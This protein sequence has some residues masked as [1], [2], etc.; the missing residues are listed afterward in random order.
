MN[1]KQALSLPGLQVYGQ[2][3]RAKDL[4]EL[5]QNYN[6]DKDMS[7]P[8]PPATKRTLQ[9]EKEATFPYHKCKC[10]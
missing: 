6:M 3:H 5:V 9:E 10:S 8:S 4:R 7:P 2:S 1:N